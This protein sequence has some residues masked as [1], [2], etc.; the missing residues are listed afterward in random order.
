LK[1]K[2]WI[3]I[4]LITISF[5]IIIISNN[6]DNKKQ[7]SLN[8]VLIM[9]DDQRW[10]TLCI[11]DEKNEVCDKLPEYPMPNIQKIL[12]TKGSVF[13]NAHV[14]NPM[15]CPS[16]SSLLS[17][18][19]YSHNTGVLTNNP[20]NGGA[21]AFGGLSNE[22]KIDDMSIS[23]IL[24]ERGYTTAIIGKYLNQYKLGSNLVNLTANKAY[25]PPGW[26]SFIIAVGMGGN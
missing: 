4:G 1:F 16:R 11:P 17:G 18:G 12:V 8:I 5:I 21:D 24:Q 25:I 14:T 2:K 3:I 26:D 19:F 6:V 23:T 22:S 10:D 15:C 9:T 13:S 20:P 7:E